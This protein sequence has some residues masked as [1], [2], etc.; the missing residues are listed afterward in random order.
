MKKGRNIVGIIL[1]ILVIIVFFVLEFW[2]GIERP[3][4]K[5]MEVENLSVIMEDIDIE[6]IFR[7]ENGKEKA[8][9]TRIYNYFKDIGLPREDVDEVVK[10]KAFKR[11]IGNYLGSMFINKTM[12]TGVVYPSKSSIVSFIHKNYDRFMKVTDFPEEYDQE[13]I[14]RIV[15]ENYKHVKDE[16]DE[17]AKDIKWDKLKNVDLIKTIMT[18]KTILIIGGLVL[19]V[20]LLIIFRKSLYIWLKWVS[21]PTIINGLIL[22]IGSFIGKG[23][24]NLFADFGSFDYLLDPLVDAILK[25]MR[26]FAIIEIALGIVSLITYMAL[27]KV[28]SK[29]KDKEIEETKEETVVEENE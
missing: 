12:G 27:N 18:T 9:G 29:P 7:D 19:C 17:L 4:N 22:L 6:R 21:I 20:V 2:L 1:S 5:T 11:I 13:E 14:T 25:N 10:D 15:N 16:L 26:L 23:I 8:Q 28:A 24:V 3:I